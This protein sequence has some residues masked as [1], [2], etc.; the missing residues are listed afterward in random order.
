VKPSVIKIIV[1]N[2]RQKLSS[3]STAIA[4]RANAVDL[5]MEPIMTAP[6]QTKNM[7]KSVFSGQILE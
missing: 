6:I 3:K 5:R 4:G 7:L 1:K 2:H